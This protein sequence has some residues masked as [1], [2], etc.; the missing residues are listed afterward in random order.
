[1]KMEGTSAAMEGRREQQGR[2]CACPH[3]LH[4]A[5]RVHC[6]LCPPEAMRYIAYIIPSMNQ[7]P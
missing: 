2:T 6:T 5:A 7:P 4:G 1:M 3:N